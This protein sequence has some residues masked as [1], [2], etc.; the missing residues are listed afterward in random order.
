MPTDLEMR[1]LSNL[2]HG[3]DIE[4]LRGLVMHVAEKG[5]EVVGAEALRIKEDRGRQLPIRHTAE[6]EPNDVTL[7]SES[8]LSHT[9]MHRTCS[10]HASM[11]DT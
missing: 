8:S 3:M 1:F 11:A 4:E 2:I 7:E 10:M 6:I 5:F 9:K